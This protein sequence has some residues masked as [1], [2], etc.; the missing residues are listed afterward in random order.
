MGKRLNFVTN[1]DFSQ[2]KT[3]QGRKISRIEVNNILKNLDFRIK[4]NACPNITLDLVHVEIII[5]FY[6]NIVPDFFFKTVVEPQP[7]C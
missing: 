5:V 1:S 7:Q 6:K 2:K 4:T 3:F